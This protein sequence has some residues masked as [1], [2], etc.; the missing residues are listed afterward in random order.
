MSE[1]FRILVRDDRGI[2]DDVCRTAL[3]ENS[4]EL[5]IFIVFGFPFGSQKILNHA[6]LKGMGDFESKS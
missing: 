5:K 6:N 3:N 4:C 1:N 2:G